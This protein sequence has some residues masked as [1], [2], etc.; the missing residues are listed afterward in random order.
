MSIEIGQMYRDAYPVG[1]RIRRFV[2]NGV[3]PFLVQVAVLEP[4][5]RKPSKHI[6][7]APH[8]FNGPHARGLVRVK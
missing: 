7:L 6:L 5:K 8:R 2:V 1:G 3:Y 4:R